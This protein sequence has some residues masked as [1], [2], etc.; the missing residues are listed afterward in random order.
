VHPEGDA[1]TTGLVQIATECRNRGWTVVLAG[2][3]EPAKQA[4]FAHCIY[5]GEFW[6]IDGTWPFG[7][8][9]QMQLRL[10]YVLKRELKNAGRKLVHV[11]M[12]SGGLD[13]Y[14]FAGHAVIYIVSQGQTG[15]DN[16][17]H[18]VV[19]DFTAQGA[20]LPFAR[21][22]STVPPKR[23]YAVDSDPAWTGLVGARRAQEHYL[24]FKAAS[25][26][27]VLPQH[28]R[29]A[30]VAAE[31]GRQVALRGFSAADLAALV[32]AIGSKLS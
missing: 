32:T 6:R 12:R 19:G 10:F 20:K 8:N 25:H 15:S 28:L 13:A 7:G 17:M 14:A 3:I 30:G 5:L 22:V 21:F 4:R 23:R 24:T 26:G 1:S 9:R 29:R 18:G 11:G 31:Y 16:R 2:A 27:G